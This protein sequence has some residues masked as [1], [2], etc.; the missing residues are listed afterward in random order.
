MGLDFH[1]QEMVLKTSVLLNKRIPF[2][3]S[4]VLARF[5][6]GMERGMPLPWWLDT[7]S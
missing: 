5:C 7:G 2:Q 3:P 6:P 4:S 1:D